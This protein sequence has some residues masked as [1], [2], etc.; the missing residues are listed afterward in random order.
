[1]ITRWPWLKIIHQCWCC[2]ACRWHLIHLTTKVL[3]T[4]HAHTHASAP[5]P[6]G[7]FVTRTPAA[8]GFLPFMLETG[9]KQSCKNVYVTENHIVGPK[10]NGYIVNH[11]TFPLTFPK[12]SQS[13]FVVDRTHYQPQFFLYLIHFHW[14]LWFIVWTFFIFMLMVHNYTNHSM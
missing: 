9:G 12:P 6:A 2:L 7:L 1:M 3:S 8:T 13:L 4:A 11:Q 10:T 5:F 14:V